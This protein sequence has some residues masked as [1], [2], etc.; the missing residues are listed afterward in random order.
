MSLQSWAVTAFAAIWALTSSA[1]SEAQPFPSKP[2]R[3]L[4]QFAPGGGVEV[5]LRVLGQKLTESGWPQV[6]I[7]NRPGGGGTLAALEA[8]RAAPDGYTL[9]LAD[10]GSHAINATLVRNLAYDPVKDFQPITLMWTFSSI[11]AV[12]AAS[13]AKTVNDL[14]GLA[15]SKPGGLNYA[16]QGPG[17]GGQLLGAMF[18]KAS[19]IPMTHVPYKG[20][21]PAIVDMIGNRVDMMFAS[22]ATLKAAV[23]AGQIRMIAV[24]S[25]QRLTEVPALPTM[26]EVGFGDVFLDAWFGL[27][28]PAGLPKEIVAAVHD[29]VVGVLH[30]PAM[31]QKITE[32]AWNVTTSTPKQF[33]ELIANDAARLGKVMKDAGIE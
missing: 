27:A 25:K 9:L 26:T 3:I 33:G 18:A 29:K 32:Q 21:G 6:I 30:S 20:A 1:P 19:G 17:S 28:G 15:T 7:D 4:T 10:I 8:K 31:S 12:P 13:P 14:L 24:T 16:S 2:V 22:Y 5:T 11:L 23:D